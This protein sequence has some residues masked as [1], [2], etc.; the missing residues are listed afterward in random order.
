MHM[1]FPHP[2]PSWQKEAETEIH[3]GQ[4]VL[5]ELQSEIDAFWTEVEKTN[6]QSPSPPTTQRQD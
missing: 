2:T 3:T 4:G 1:A 5:D 6:S